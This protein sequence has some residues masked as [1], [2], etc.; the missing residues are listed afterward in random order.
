MQA[1][2]LGAHILGLA[3]CERFIRSSKVGDRLARQPPRNALIEQLIGCD[4]LRPFCLPCL[5]EWPTVM[6]GGFNRS[7]QHTKN[8]VGRRS[9]ADEA[10]E[11]NLLLG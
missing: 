1:A 4:F 9:V 2:I 11:T 7:M 8:C 6:Y 3:H 10:A 5:P